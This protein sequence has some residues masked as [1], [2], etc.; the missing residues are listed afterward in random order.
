MV[1]RIPHDLRR[2]GVKHYIDAGN[3]P[4]VV[5]QWSR[6]WTMSMLLRYHIID[7]H[8][9]RRTGQ[10]ASRYRGAREAV[11]PLDVARTDSELTKS[12]S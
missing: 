2:S 9:L 4:H 7:P 5:M 8:D 3:D 6:H 11:I 1:A 10:R 12:A